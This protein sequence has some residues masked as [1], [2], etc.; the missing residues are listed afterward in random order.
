MQEKMIRVKYIGGHSEVENVAG[1][2]K[3]SD[4]GFIGKVCLSGVD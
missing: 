4:L 2:W 3:R 1:L